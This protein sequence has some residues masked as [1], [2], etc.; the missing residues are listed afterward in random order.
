[1]AQLEIK[2]AVVEDS[3]IDAATC[4]EFLNRYASDR[5]H[6]FHIDR[7]PGG[8]S[9]LT[10]F[11][12]QYDFIIFD[13]QLGDRNGIDVAKEV[14]KVDEEVIIM[15]ETNLGKYATSGYEVAA[16]DYV[17]KPLNY[18][19]LSLKL[20]RVMR[21]LSRHDSGASIVVKMESGYA[22]VNVDDVFYLEIFGH[23]I[24]FHESEKKTATYGTLKEYESMLSNYH[25]LRCNSCYLVNAAK[26]MEIKQYDLLLSNGETIKI[27]HPRRKEFVNEFKRYMMEKRG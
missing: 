8:N 13:V 3:D 14:R 12:S 10:K 1:M 11:K 23:D 19:S 20:D 2:I 21:Q 17:L 7:Y 15:F 4:L 22:K 25:F 6:I 16:I 27:S 5:G 26:I 18:A 9:F 24:V